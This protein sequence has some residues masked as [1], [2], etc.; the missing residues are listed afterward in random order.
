MLLLVIQPVKP[1]GEASWCRH[2]H[3]LPSRPIRHSADRPLTPCPPVNPA[4]KL[5]SYSIHMAPCAFFPLL[6]TQHKSTAAHSASAAVAPS[7]IFLF[8]PAIQLAHK[9]SARALPR[10][11]PLPTC[12]REREFLAAESSINHMDPEIPFQPNPLTTPHLKQP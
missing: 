6:K 9:N 1:F 5:R 2:V 10:R 11:H 3:P 4:N 7:P 12:K 8:N